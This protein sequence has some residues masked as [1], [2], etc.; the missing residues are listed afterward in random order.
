[1]DPPRKPPNVWI[2]AGVTYGLVIVTT[3]IALLAYHYLLPRTNREEPEKAGNIAVGSVWISMYPGAVVHDATSST[4]EQVT[5]G[6]LKFG[7]GDPPDKMLAFY[8][9][10]LHKSGFQIEANTGLR[11]IRAIGYAGKVEV[12]VSADLRNQGS[13]IQISTMDRRKR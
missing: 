3:I 12:V 4:H 1:M 2:L 9:T 7:S 13:E 6:T 8:R 11:T 10:T 5:E